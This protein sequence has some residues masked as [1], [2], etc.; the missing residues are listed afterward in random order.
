M[1][2]QLWSNID[3]TTMQSKIKTSVACKRPFHWISKK[4]R[5]VRAAREISK[6]QN[7]KTDQF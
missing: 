7:F 3:K 1:L 6:F 4:S 2:A 5:L